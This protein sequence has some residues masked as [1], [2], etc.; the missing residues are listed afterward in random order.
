MAGDSSWMS[1]A[2]RPGSAARK[3]GGREI[4]ARVVPIENKLR[5]RACAPS[6]SP[7]SEYDDERSW[8]DGAGGAPVRR[9]RIRRRRRLVPGADV[10]GMPSRDHRGLFR[11]QRRD[12]LRAVPDADRERPARRVGRGPL[13]SRLGARLPG[14]DRGVRDLLRHPEDDGLR[15]RPDRHPGWP[16]G[17]QGR[18]S[19]LARPGR[20]ALPTHGDVPRLH[21]RRRELWRGVHPQDVGGSGGAG[22]GR[23]GR[24][25]GQTGRAGCRRQ[26]RARGGRAGRQ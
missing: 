22:R 2:P 12:R 24:R 14:G 3:R 17:R 8:R 26:G 16:D 5:L 23:E 10:R 6:P 11:D 19:G 9:G 7:T 13:F 18:P 15:D 20:L 21:G 1:R 25:E 4:D